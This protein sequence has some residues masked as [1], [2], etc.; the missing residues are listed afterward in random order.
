MKV[1]EH[2]GLRDMGAED[3]VGEDGG[4]PGDGAKLAG[5][6][7]VGELESLGEV[8]WGALAAKD[9]QEVGEV[10][11]RDSLVQGDT[12]SLAVDRAEV[13]V[14]LL[15]LSVHMVRGDTLELDGEGV[16]V[17][18][19]LDLVAGTLDASGK[20]GSEAVHTLGNGGEALGTV[21]ES[22][23]G[24]HVG[25]KG[26]GS[27]DVAGGLLPANVL[28]PGLESQAEGL[29]TLGVAGDTDK[30]AGHLPL[31]GILDTKEGGV[32]ATVAKGNSKPL[33]VAKGNVRTKLAGGLELGEG[34]KVGGDAQ[35]GA[36]LVGLLRD[37]GQVV[38]LTVGIRILNEHSEDILKAREKKREGDE[39]REVG[40]WRRMNE[41]SS[42]L[43]V[44]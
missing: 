32:R 8:L 38:D 2:L 13:N 21:V 27:A 5:I 14:P 16:K 7:N 31:Q 6:V 33:A 10:L 3:R 40:T 25:E 30:T 1:A 34:K 19:V 20:D 37:G 24:G 44:L 4:L 23:H 41:V 26:L 29:V 42:P 39:I 35:E 9:M 18:R 15:G 43:W 12:H 11:L 36:V 28:L 22:V 17:L